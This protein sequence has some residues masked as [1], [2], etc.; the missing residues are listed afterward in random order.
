MSLKK[1]SVL[2]SEISGRFTSGSDQWTGQEVED[3]LIDI[4]DSK[5]YGV[6][7]SFSADIPFSQPLTFMVH[8]VTGA[9]AFT[10]NTTGAKA[11]SVT[12][13]RLTANGSN[14]PTFSGTFKKSAASA[15]YTNTASLLNVIYF[16][17]D[18][19]DYWYSI[20]KAA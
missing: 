7:D 14:V 9:I 17:F 3:S 1:D 6:S 20:D 18:G 8:S 5:G 11:G 4:V 2:S 15:N 16:W 19:T 12:V 13:V 10:A